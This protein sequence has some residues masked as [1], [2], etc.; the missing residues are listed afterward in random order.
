MMSARNFMEQMVAK[1]TLCQKLSGIYKS[2]GACFNFGIKECNGACIGL[3]SAEIYNK[4]AE[5]LLSDLKY[6]HQSFLIIDKGRTH[7]E[8]SIIYVNN[9]SYRGFGYVSTEFDINDLET[10]KDCIKPFNDNRDIQ[11]II[12]GYID[13]NKGLTIIPLD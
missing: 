2:S 3:E 11:I 7:S 4:R 9:G 1:H 6:R 13:R 5:K 12:K 8:K 10:L